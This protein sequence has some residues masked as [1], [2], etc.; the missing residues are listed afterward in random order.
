MNKIIYLFLVLLVTAGLS[1]C[2]KKFEQ[3]NTDPTQFI[4]ATPEALLA[5]SI[6]RTGDWVGATGLNNGINVNMWEIANFGTAVGRYANGDQ[7][8]WQNFYVTVLQNLTQIETQFGNDPL[9]KNRVQIARIWKA[10]VYSILTG[11]FG[12]I[13]LTEAN[14]ANY[15]TEINFE[16]EDS[17]YVKILR[18]LKT[19]STTIDVNNTKD[20]LAYDVVYGTSATQLQRW[21]KFANTLRLKIALRCRRNLGSLADAEVRDVMGNE[22]ALIGTE[23]ETA[24]VAYENVIGNENP[25]YKTYIRSNF[26]SFFPRMSDIM[27]MYLRSYKDPRINYYFDSVRLTSRFRVTDTVKST[28]NDSLYVVTY[29]IPHYGITKSGRLLP[30]WTP[31][32]TGGI[33]PQ[34]QANNGGINGVSAYSMFSLNILNN[35]TRPLIVLGFAEAEF[36][37]AQASILGLGGARTP[38]NYYTSGIDAN[39]AFWK[40]PASLREIYKSGN[41]IK[42]GTTGTGL[43]DYL[44][45]VNA[46]IPSGDINK[47]YHQLW[48]NYFPDQPFDAWC[49]QRQTRVLNLSPHTNP[50]FASLLFQDIPGRGFYPLSVSAQNPVGY[51]GALKQLGI[52]NFTEETTNPYNNLKFALPYTA[53]NFDTKLVFYDLSGMNKWYGT[54]IQSVRSAGLASRFTVLVTKTYKP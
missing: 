3:L 10:Y 29:P 24:Q 13:P 38:E 6:K 41:G 28:L 4:N 47:I 43:W 12:S 40:I 39:F 46:N 9:Y 27:F 30:G 18:M 25:Y 33:N 8:V 45:L 49:L 1:S 31:Q 5:V 37:K 52:P 36:L 16:S 32:L 26:A 23:N 20:R 35:P 14:N 19:A 54:T 21:V 7:G 15:L 34:G 42:F 48:L 2:T 51:A 11:Y 44:H 17:A 50:S 53:P 22:A